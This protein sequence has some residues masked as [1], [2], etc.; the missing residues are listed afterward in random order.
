MWS[1][2]GKRLWQAYWSDRSRAGGRGPMR[3]PVLGRE[4]RD[5][6]KQRSIARTVHWGKWSEILFWLT[7]RERNMMMSKRFKTNVSVMFA[8]NGDKLGFLGRWIENG[9][10]YRKAGLGDQFIDGRNCLKRLRAAFEHLLKRIGRL[11]DACYA[12]RS[13]TKRNDSKSDGE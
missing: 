5:S 11:R 6:E 10:A 9:V 13:D 1:K 4:R 12:S 3:G 8:I 7:N 2:R